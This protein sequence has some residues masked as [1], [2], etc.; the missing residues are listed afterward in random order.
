M[1]TK[2][3]IDPSEKK[4]QTHICREWI[5]NNLYQVGLRVH[6]DQNIRDK[7]YVPPHQV[8]FLPSDGR[9]FAAAFKAGHG[10]E[11]CSKKLQ[12]EKPTCFLQVQSSIEWRFAN[13]NR[14]Q[15]QLRRQPLPSLLLSCSSLNTRQTNEYIKVRLT[16]NSYLF[17]ANT[18][19]A[20][21]VLI[22][23]F[24]VALFLQF[25]HIAASKSHTT[26]S[27]RESGRLFVVISISKPPIFIKYRKIRRG[28]TPF[29]ESDELLT[30]FNL[31][32][33]D[34]FRPPLNSRTLKSACQEH[35]QT[36]LLTFTRK[37][38]IRWS[39]I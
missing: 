9:D 4:K 29:E 12:I 27:E 13:K 36:L 5:L 18:K 32:S 28:S 30:S 24:P 22:C 25:A 37:T 31:N 10:C 16:Q 35:Q 14:R 7:S 21:S 34:I 26:L 2:D 3:E 20:T 19:R 1:L 39:I 8:L 23:I 6:F 17:Y 15:Q 11:N 33:L 38:L